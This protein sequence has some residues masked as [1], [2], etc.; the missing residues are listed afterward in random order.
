MR[1]FLDNHLAPALARSLHAL[2]EREGDEVYHLKS[3]FD[4][5]TSDIDWIRTLAEEG[6]WIVLSGDFR[7]I[8]RPHEKRIW[9]SAR[10][11]GFFLAKGWINAT[12][13]DQAWR[14]VRWWPQ[15]AAQARRVEAGA[16]FQIPFATTG[17]FRILPPG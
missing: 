8:R 15:I 7:I 14:L 5:A 3:R 4:G 2:S 12:F 16:T 17:K 9:Q 13:W 6:G 10:L 11:T 1:F